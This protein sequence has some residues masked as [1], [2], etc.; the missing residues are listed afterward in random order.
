MAAIFLVIVRFMPQGNFLLSDFCH[1][2][3]V[4]LNAAWNSKRW[5]LL[6]EDPAHV[7][8][9]ASDRQH[10][11]GRFQAVPTAKKKLSVAVALSG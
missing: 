7:V 3:P 8:E 9:Q 4:G 5:C 2:L 1:E 11:R 10:D 6:L